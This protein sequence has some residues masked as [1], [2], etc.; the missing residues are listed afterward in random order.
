MKHGYSNHRARPTFLRW[1]AGLGLIGATPRIS[2]A[3][4]HNGKKRWRLKT[5]KRQ[6]PKPPLP[7][8]CAAT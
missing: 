4:P 6:I 3:A 5:G 7:C 1:L 2:S 8:F